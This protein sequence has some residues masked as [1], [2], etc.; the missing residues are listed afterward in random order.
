MENN[1]EWHHHVP[2]PDELALA[3]QELEAAEA[4]LMAATGTEAANEVHA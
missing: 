1:V 2:T 3:L 4:L